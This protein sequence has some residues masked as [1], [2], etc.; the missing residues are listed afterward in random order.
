VTARS[1]RQVAYEALL[2]IDHDGAYA[3]L[4]LA[5][6]LGA[7]GLE[8]R[9]R[10]FATELVYGTTRMR[11]ACDFSVD[12]FLRRPP[13]PELRTLLRLGAYQLLMAGV[14]PH[15]AVSATVALA[16]RAARP[17]VNA[18][19]RR[20]AAAGPPAWPDEATR[21][22]YPDWIV[23]RLT[24]ELGERVARDALERMNE[25][26]VVTTRADG[27]IQDRSSVWVADL[28]EAERGDRVADLCA[29]P[30]GKATRLAEG[31]ALV[32]AG[33]VRPARARL[34]A[35]SA[36]TLGLDRGQLSV[37]VADGTAPPLRPG[38]FDRVLVDAPCSGLG[39]LRRRPDARWRIEPVDVDALAA[40]QHGLLVAGRTLVR[41]GGVLVYSVCTL[42]AAES[43]DHDV[44]GWPALDPPPR[45]WQPYGRGGRLLPQDAGTDGM[46]VLRYRRP[47]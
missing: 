43:I 23:A 9:D 21:L 35:A 29:A 15:A 45:P 34:V 22:S 36:R 27:Y 1:A 38:A 32:V 42:T 7:S 26:P 46:V 12:R 30:G 3:N 33:D 16:P 25:R 8:R 4:V 20:L 14:A 2:R 6:M 41:P 17:F 39:T 28:V 40:L 13:A 47:S 19:L 31:G 37:A 11:R 18:V 10:G 5:P 44:T 24:R